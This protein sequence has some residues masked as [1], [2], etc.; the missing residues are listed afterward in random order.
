MFTV[1]VLHS[2]NYDKIYI[3]FTSDLQQRLK[4]HNELGIKGWT[5]KFRPWILAYTEEY[6]LKPE[7]MKREKELK[8]ATGRRFL[9]ERI[10]SQGSYPPAGGQKFDPSLR[11]QKS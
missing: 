2:V 11:N 3:G 6:L 1:Y 9:W 5:I 7:A 4:S 10:K 8:T